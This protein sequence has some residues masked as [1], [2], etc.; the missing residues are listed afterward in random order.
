M[1]NSNVSR[2]FKFY[3]TVE[4][5]EVDWNEGSTVEG[6]EESRIR[7]YREHDRSGETEGNELGITEE[8][9]NKSS[10]TS[11][12]RPKLVKQVK[13]STQIAMKAVAPTEREPALS[14]PTENNTITKQ[15]KLEPKTRKTYFVPT[16][17][18]TPVAKGTL[19]VTTHVSKM[20]SNK[21]THEPKVSPDKTKPLPDRLTVAPKVS[22]DKTTPIPEDTPKHT[23]NDKAV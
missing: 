4:V 12:Q 14:M 11:V 1:N 16:V 6:N 20:R 15:S 22:P 21:L 18:T 17:R 23:E 13:Q 2:S 19:D 9:Q 3:L 8:W 10:K 7:K 5:G